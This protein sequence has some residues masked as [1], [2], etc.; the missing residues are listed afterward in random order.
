MRK[1]IKGNLQTNIPQASHAE[2]VTRLLECGKIRIERICSQGQTSPWYDQAQDE[3]VLLF[4]GKATLELADGT[5]L[6][7]TKGDWLFLPAHCRDRVSWTSPEETCIWLAVH[8]E[9]PVDFRNTP[10]KNRPF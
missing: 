6:Q 10:P 1:P 9:A 5:E 8:M 4:Q 7:L 2:V 3:F